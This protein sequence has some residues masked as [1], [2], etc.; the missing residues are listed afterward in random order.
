MFRIMFY[1]SLCN[2]EM[3]K[4]KSESSKIILYWLRLFSG[5]IFF[6]YFE[7]HLMKISGNYEISLI[8]IYCEDILNQQPKSTNSILH[9]GK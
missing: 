9:T 1:K 7:R 8:Y 2:H 3:I 6:C 4:T 5:N